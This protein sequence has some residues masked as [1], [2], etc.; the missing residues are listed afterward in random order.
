MALSRNQLEAI[1]LWL[2]Y[3]RFTSADTHRR[4]ARRIDMDPQLKAE[5]LREQARRVS[6]I[7]K[8][9]KA[10]Q[11]EIDALTAAGEG[12]AD[13]AEHDQENT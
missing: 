11:R 3:V 12:G 10:V 4:N 5:L 6:E 13:D 9:E 2:K 1:Q 7:R 8:L